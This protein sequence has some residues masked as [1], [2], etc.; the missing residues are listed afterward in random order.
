M[1]SESRGL[2]E[3]IFMSFQKEFA[4]PTVL[5]HSDL[6]SIYIFSGDP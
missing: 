4:Y 6:Q 3:K 1:D 2:D 5:P